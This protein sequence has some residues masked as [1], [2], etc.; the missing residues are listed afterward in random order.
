MNF[1][2]LV[3]DS[4]LRSEESSAGQ[5]E[6]FQILLGPAGIHDHSF[7][8][9]P[10]RVI[11]NHEAA[12]V[13]MAVDPVTAAASLELESIL[14]QRLDELPGSNPP[15]KAHQKLTATTGEDMT[16]APRSGS[17]GIGSPAARRSS[18]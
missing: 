5:S 15:A 11:R 6:P 12:A 17:S 18:R 9:R 1:W 4:Q 2:F 16:I 8:G 13:W 3:A 7:Q 14:V 10:K